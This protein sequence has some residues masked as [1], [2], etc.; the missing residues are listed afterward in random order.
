MPRPE[1]HALNESGQPEQ[2]HEERP[3][4]AHA[5]Q[6]PAPATRA[7]A[8][9]KKAQAAQ[10]VNAALARVAL[11]RC[12]PGLTM[13][14]AGALADQLAALAAGASR[15]ELAAVLGACRE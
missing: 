11:C 4:E 1:R 13:E 9:E 14:Q 8:N 12:V 7:D 3:H 10:G 15:E 2:T 5:E 6:Q